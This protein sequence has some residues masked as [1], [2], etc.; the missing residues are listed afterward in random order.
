MGK[1]KITYDEFSKKVGEK[2]NNAKAELLIPG[3]RNEMGMLYTASRITTALKNMFHT[4]GNG[5]FEP[6]DA[7]YQAFSERPGLNDVTNV[8]GVD[9][10]DI[11][12]ASSI[13]SLI[14][15]LAIERPMNQP[16]DLVYFQK[17][18]AINAMGG[19]AENETVVHPFKP[20]GTK[21]DI[22][23]SGTVRRLSGDGAD[24]DIDLAFGVPIAK[25]TLTLEAKT[26]GQPDTTYVTIGMDREG[27]GKALLSR[28][29]VDSVTIDYET[30]DVSVK[31]VPTGTTVRVSIFVERSVQQDGANTLRVKPATDQKT[32]YSYPNRV[33]LENNL[34]NQAYMNKMAHELQN[35][36]VEIDYGQVAIRQ[37]LEA[38]IQ[39]I[40]TR[41]VNTVM[42]TA[43]ILGTSDY[44]SLD[45][46]SYFGAAGF[47]KFAPTKDDKVVKFFIDLNT[48]LLKRCGR[49]ITCYVTGS[50]GT[51][52]MAGIKDAFKPNDAFHNN[53]DGM[54]G[55]FNGVP[56][57]RHQAA[58]GSESS[59]IATYF[60]IHKTP[61]GKM[62]PV[63]YG[64]FLPLYSTRPAINYDNPTQFAQA[65]FSQDAIDSIVPEFVTAGTVKFA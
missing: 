52:I 24:A 14:P 8:A 40:N 47:D 55:T 32:I 33:I 26:T 60:A 57:V 12:I 6:I 22:S 15:Y 37:M 65:I 36:G 3:Q 41:L 1:K 27:D 50:Q 61:D 62:G 20:I 56:V 39:F 30:G 5:V 63:V 10:V 44:P 38:Y 64:D 43:A 17:L 58:S 42:L 49:G 2:L 13:A 23:L 25:K 28:G 53:L 51:N 54:V 48:S 35:S 4:L 29:I 16:A 21:M 7:I 46:S 11:T 31:T 9:V 34:E 19:F 45:A 18:I 59:S